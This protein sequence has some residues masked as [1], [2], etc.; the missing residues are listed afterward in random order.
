MQFFGLLFLLMYLQVTLI[1]SDF[2]SAQSFHLPA[3]GSV[4]VIL[5]GNGTGIAPFRA[6]WQQ[7]MFD[8]NNKCPPESSVTGRRQWGDMRLIFGC[9]NSRLDDI[10]RH[11]IQK[12]VHSRAISSVST[13]Y[14]RE[15][16]KAKVY[17]YKYEILKSE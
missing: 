2:S 14:S 11:E 6:F 17:M 1:S 7:R 15:E 5:I 9:R 13:A 10:Y 12:A 4:P 3:D 16:G 8:N